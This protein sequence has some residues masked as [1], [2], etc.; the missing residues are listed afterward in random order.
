MLIADDLLL[1]YKRCQRRAFLNV[2]G[3]GQEKDPEREFVS[4]LRSQGSE[5]IAAILADYHYHTPR[6]ARR[7]WQAGAI[8]TT[9]LMAQGVD[10]VHSGVLKLNRDTELLPTFWPSAVTPTPANAPIL[11]VEA[12]LR[13][14][15]LELLGKP[16]LL[17]KQPGKS[18][19]GDWQYIPVSVK[20]GK[21]P[22]PEYKLV[23]ALHT[24]LLAVIQKAIP[25]QTYLI[26]RDRDE[27]SV[28][29]NIWLPRLW[30]VLAEASEMLLQA[31]EPEVFI[32]RQR[33]SLCQW[34]S[35]CHAI[36]IAQ[37]HLSLVPGVTPNRYEQLQNLGI[38][39]L[40]TLAAT[41]PQ[42]LK[43]TLGN[44]L[45]WNLQQQAWAIVSNQPLKK[46][47]KRHLPP[48]P[49]RE[50]EFYFDIEAEP[51][52][53]LDY[54]LGVVRVDR[55]Q[56]QAQFFPLV[57]EVPTAEAEIWQQ[58][59]TLIES[60]PEA[61]IFHFSEYEVETIQRLARL[62][63][64]PTNRVQAIISRCVDLHH[65]VT[66][67]AI[68]PVQSYSLK[69]IAQW[70]GFQWRDA[71]ASGDQTV[72]WYD[73]WLKTGDRH[74]LEAIIRYN[75]DDCRATYRLKEWLA[76]FLE[77]ATTEPVI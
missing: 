74:C 14:R 2:Y 67:T 17:L 38:Q 73:R 44:D 69:A 3:D 7:D 46:P 22:K 75:E 63:E 28:N 49:H 12:R 29:L 6:F 62:Y 15:A 26:L 34:Y 64:T 58:F 37:N 50:I 54:L 4:K 57:A 9:A 65:Y 27:H 48:L 47:Q 11:A 20:L 53:N 40:E 25:T 32:S 43:S 66:A 51:D 1:D 36:A 70:L 52:R 8:A 18:R 72:C 61:P 68:L 24:Y 76:D 35:H 55:R 23:S 5:H 31:T 59:L 71:D 45:A 21:R 33:C 60:E 19:W 39:T 30:E 41:S 10:C 42:Q 13:L 16:T 56:N 77:T